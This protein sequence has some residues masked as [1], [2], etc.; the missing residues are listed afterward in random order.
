MRKGPN[1]DSNDEPRDDIDQEIA[2]F[3]PTQGEL[4]ALARHWTIE[5]YK[6]HLDCFYT[7]AICGMDFRWMLYCQKRRSR[8][9]EWITGE[10]LKQ[11][12]AVALDEFGASLDPEHWQI[13]RDGTPE[14]LEAHR[15]EM[16]NRWMG[17]DD[18]N[19]SG[20]AEAHPS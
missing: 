7:G 15:L 13:L 10:D 14:Q 12:D 2:G 3:N 1:S 19:D 20:D 6:T 16:Q 5:M 8:V 9:A 17:S 18:D 4:M 11:A